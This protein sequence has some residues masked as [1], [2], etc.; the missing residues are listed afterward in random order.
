MTSENLKVVMMAG[1]TGGHVFPALAI[2]DELRARGAEVTWLGTSRG[3]EARLVPNAGI[4]LHTLTIEG[5]RGKGLVA[6]L[7]APFRLI[8]AISQAR[9][10]LIDEGADVVVGLGGFA[11]GPGGVAAKSMGVPLLIHEQNAVAGTT[12]RI[13]AKLA[14][15][16]YEAF[17]NSL[18]R[19]KVTGNPVRQSIADVH[20]VDL[21]DG[22]RPLKLLVLGGSL[23]AQAL[24]EIVPE[25]LSKLADDIE[26]QV[27]HQ[28]GERLHE[29]AVETFK[30]KGVD[31][32]VRPFI[33]DMAEAYGWADLVVCRSGALTVSELAAAG[34]AAFLVPYPHA[35]DDHQTKNGE[36][37]VNQGAAVIHQQA[38]LRASDL[39]RFIETMYRDRKR[40]QAMSDASR[41]LGTTNAAAIVAD[42]CQEVA[43]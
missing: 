41:K 25:A 18:P 11:S 36:W 8:Q 38:E 5:V 12:N 37:L 1:G 28:T 24:N 9:R 35:I 16:V 27:I 15:R 3:I 43:N 34:R 10:V 7:K 39:S 19:A 4:K 13:L 40:L 17:P 26:L 20:P 31:A 14:T 42:G 21:S 29:Q 6:L 32:D 33:A 2:A 23:G 22:E 30:E